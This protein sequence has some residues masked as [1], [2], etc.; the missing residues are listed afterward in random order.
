LV[1]NAPGQ[2]G[3][4][5]A[6]RVIDEIDRA[7]E[8][9]YEELTDS[10]PPTFRSRRS[11]RAPSQAPAPSREDITTGGGNYDGI[12]PA[13]LMAQIIGHLQSWR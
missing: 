13:E 7:A 5:I 4:T 1:R 10:C 3:V 12:E 2:I 8:P 6:D 9:V 11:T